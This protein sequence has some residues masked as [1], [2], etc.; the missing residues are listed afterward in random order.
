MRKI[1]VATVFSGIGSFEFALKRM[2][3]EH[4][5]LFA[6]DNGGI[7][8]EV[9]YTKELEYIR[10]LESTNDKKQYVDNLYTKSSKKKNYVKQSYLKNYSLD[11]NNYYMDL[12]LLDGRPFYRQVDIFVG[13]SPCQSFS[14]IGS[15]KGLDD[16]RGT[17]FYD[18][19]RL[20]NEMQPRIFIFENVR[21]LYNH[22]KGKTWEIIKNTFN[23]LGYKIYS[24][25]LNSSDFG[26]PQT[27]RRLFVIGF[28]DDTDFTFPMPTELKYTLQDFLIDKNSIGSVISHD[29]KILMNYAPGIVE[30]KY[31]LSDK[32]KDYVMKPGTKSFYQKPEIDLTIARTILS[33]MGNKHRAGI[34]NYVTTNGK[35]RMLTEREAHRLMGFTDEYNIVV[36][37]AQAYMQAGNSIVVDV[38]IGI[39]KEI[40]D[41]KLLGV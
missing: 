26:I 34:D 11:E 10:S 8:I 27:R 14:S 13:G 29:S 4:D 38:F 41:L 16:A 6:C 1:K 3:I 37:R 12:R 25:I 31:F 39:L 32:V 17:L 28:K 23:S 5:V 7:E 40:F 36:S 30:E 24:Q 2:N 22:D 21:G 18:F 33:T 20:I 9:D 35:I 19:A 15:Q